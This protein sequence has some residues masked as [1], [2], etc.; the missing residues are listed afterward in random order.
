LQTGVE[1]LQLQ[2]SVVGIGQRRHSDRPARRPRGIEMQRVDLAN[3]PQAIQRMP[4]GGSG[5]R[6]PAAQS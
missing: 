1:I 3:G 6:R 5:A 4:G 2:L